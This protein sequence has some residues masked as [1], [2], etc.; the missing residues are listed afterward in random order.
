MYI[1]NYFIFNVIFTHDEMITIDISR[2]R[3]TK[4]SMRTIRT[5]RTL[6]RNMMGNVYRRDVRILS[7]ST[8]NGFLMCNVHIVHTRIIRTV[9]SELLTIPVA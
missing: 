1:Y 8:R 6:R 4:H 3:R 7:M 2:D 9:L 5:M